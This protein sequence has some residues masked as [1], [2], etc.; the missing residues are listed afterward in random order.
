MQ[1][2]CFA[3]S[4][5]YAVLIGGVVTTVIT[6]CSVLANIVKSDGVLGKII[7]YGAVNIKT[8]K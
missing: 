3:V 1:E 4:E 6:I 8:K 5:G 7:N 2:I